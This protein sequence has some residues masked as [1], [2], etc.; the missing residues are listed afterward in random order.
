MWKKDFF[1]ICLITKK[2]ENYIGRY[3]DAQFYSP[4]TMSKEER[5]E[6]FQWYS[7]VCIN[8]FNLKI[9]L[10]KYCIQD[11]SIL[12]QACMKFRKIFLQAGKVDPFT[13][14]ITIASACS[15]VYRKNFYVKTL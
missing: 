4:D 7:E 12:R 9:E 11:V 13:E 14:S 10:K 8:E 5:N 6:F 3:P 15:Q 2:N 1:H